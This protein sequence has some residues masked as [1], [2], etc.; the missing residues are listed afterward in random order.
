MALACFLPGAGLR[1]SEAVALEL[2]KHLS[3]DCSIVYV[4]QQ[5]GKKGEAV[6]SSKLHAN[7]ESWLPCTSS[8][9]FIYCDRLRFLKIFDF[10]LGSLL[11]SMSFVV[12]WPVASE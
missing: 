10:F 3:P 1:V 7:R 4:R 2:G 8:P 6:N 12:T 11:D 5:R 9:V